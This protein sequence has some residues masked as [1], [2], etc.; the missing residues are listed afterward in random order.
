[1]AVVVGTLGLTALVVRTL[2]RTFFSPTIR[3]SW[4]CRCG[5][6]QGTIRAKCEDT[7]RLHCYCQDCRDYATVI[8]NLNNDA[9][10]SKGNNDNKKQYHQITSNMIYPC[11]ESH[12]LQVCKSAVSIHKGRE[13]LKLARKTPSNK[14]MFRYYAGCCCV[15][16]MNTFS[17]LGFVGMYEDNIVN[18]DNFLLRN[19]FY[20]PV[21]VF[22]KEA[23]KQPV[24]DKVAELPVGRVLWNLFR[25]MPWTKAGPF[26]YTLQP[27]VYW[28]DEIKRE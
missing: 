26:D 21:C 7:I 14:G 9:T 3:A 2:K 12:L 28:G 17:F 25:Y 16:I 24:E 20:G 23:V 4:S 1:V 22:T 10:D 15:P 27:T 13:H 6:I 8:A 5:K 11:G 18:D 19:Q